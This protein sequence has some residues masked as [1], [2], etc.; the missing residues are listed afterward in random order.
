MAHGT[1]GTQAGRHLGGRMQRSL[2]AHLPHR[3]EAALPQAR[4]GDG[5]PNENDVEQPNGPAASEGNE[6]EPLARLPCS[7]PKVHAVTRLREQLRLRLCGHLHSQH[8]RV[9]S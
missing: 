2:P 6:G 1:H 4:Q 8:H 7:Q 9:A 3:P 5:Q